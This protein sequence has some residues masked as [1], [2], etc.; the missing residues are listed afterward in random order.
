MKTENPSSHTSSTA[1]KDGS[2]NKQQGLP[3]QELTTWSQDSLTESCRNPLVFSIQVFLTRTIIIFSGLS[4]P[5][6]SC[7][8][9]NIS[10]LY[11]HMILI[12][13]YISIYMCRDRCLDRQIDIDQ[14]SFFPIFEDRNIKIWLLKPTGFPPRNPLPSHQAHGTLQ[15][16]L[17]LAAADTSRSRVCYPSA[18]LFSRQEASPETQSAAL[19]S[20]SVLL[21]VA[22]APEE[23]RF[24][25]KINLN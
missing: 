24:K 14:E 2:G 9:C 3:T 4:P 19:A 13:R 25:N 11:P 6:L 20:S 18:T 17:D 1:V 16:N 12:Y 7:S 5:S 21:M 10:C 22:E 8:G 15:H 23:I